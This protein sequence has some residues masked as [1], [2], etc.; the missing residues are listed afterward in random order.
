MRVAVLGLGRMGRRHLQIVSQL[1]WDVAGIADRSEASVEAAAAEWNVPLERRFT[2]PERLV[3]E[4]RPECVIVA[5]TAPAHAQLTC[6]AAESGARFVLCEK[7]MARSL[8]EC[9][10]MVDVCRKNATRLAINHQMRF[11]DQY[12]RAREVLDSDEFGG[13]SSITVVAGNI[14]MA[15]NATHYFELL[16]WMTG[17]ELRDVTAWFADGTIP[18]PRGTE[19]EDRAG[20][21][22]VTT[23]GGKRL[24]LE[25]GPD[26]GHGL[27]VVYGGKYGV[28]V[29]DEIAGTVSLS[30]RE[31]GDRARPTTQYATRA[32]DREFTVAPVEAVAPSRAVLEALV[33]GA[34]VPTGEHGRMAVAALVAAHVSHENGHTAVSLADANLPVARI[35][36]YA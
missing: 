2:D 24:Y 26:Q 34:D 4:L 21:V 6:L 29:A 32:I 28:M 22:R 1:G 3:A 19:F 36:A 9:D 31:A 16:R 35:F 27:R 11:M 25:I 33:S 5:V 8:E 15:M 18:N 17:E 23:M 10:R 13:L 12:L 20:S 30:V 14:G 7:P